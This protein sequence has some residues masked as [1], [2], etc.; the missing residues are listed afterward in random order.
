MVLA[1]RLSGFA[2]RMLACLVLLTAVG[3]AK[4]DTPRGSLW[5]LAPLQRPAVPEVRDSSWVR[6]P[7]DA[8]VAA[9]FDEAGLAPLPEADRRTLLRRLS[10][11]LT[12]LP[13]TAAEIDAFVRDASPDAY[14][15]QVERL[16]ASPRYGERWAQHWLDVVRYADSDGFEYDT[17]RPHAWRYRDWVIQAFNVDKP[18]ARFVAEQIAGDELLPGDIDARVATGL[19]RLGPLRK[20]AGFQFVE[21]ERQEFL[22]EM[23]DAVGAAFLG[24]TIGCAKC[25]DHKFDPISQADYYRLQAFFAGTIAQDHTLATAAQEKAHKDLMAVWTE[26]EKTFQDELTTLEEPYRKEIESDRLAQLSQSVRDAHATPAEKRTLDQKFLANRASAFL[27]ISPTDLLARLTAEDVARWRQIQERIEGHVVAKPAPLPTVRTVM[28]HASEQPATYVLKGGIVGARAALV[29]PGFPSAVAVDEVVPLAVISSTDSDGVDSNDTG[30]E[31][32][33]VVSAGTHGRRT[34]LARW[35]VSKQHPLTARV[36]VNRLWQHH[37]RGGLVLTPGDFGH[38]GS[39]PTH[40]RLLSWLASEFLRSGGSTKAMH[41]LL[42]HSAT[43]RQRTRRTRRG[44]MEQELLVGQTRL[45]LDAEALRDSALAVAGELNVQAGGPGVRLPLLEAIAQQMYVGK[46]RPDSDEAQHR[47]RSIYRFV[48][49]NL[50]PALFWAFDAPSTVVSCAER[51]VST[52]TA[53]ALDLLNGPFL[54]GQAVAF[55]HRVL[56]EVHSEVPEALVE[57]VYTHAFGRAPT[58]HEK[59]L[60]EEFLAAQQAAIAGEGTAAARH[61]IQAALVDYCLTVFNLDEFLFVE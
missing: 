47:R 46:W 26:R 25:H 59:R 3:H 30:A 51:T 39:E 4:D 57:R 13:P 53:Q 44:S 43:Y 45:R 28:E 17:P 27:K 7:V 31:H 54:N 33:G 1:M 41:R 16:L 40:P 36:F 42:V 8:F 15:R 6:T 37:F 29:E 48:K 35:L 38:M 21:K 50:Q 19:H 60:G 56:K 34:M 49:R 24:L 58:S 5:S 11:D 18:Y 20:N 2:L 22:V 32:E 23:T 14:E 10:Y 61:A 52:H 9:R 55:A 12:G